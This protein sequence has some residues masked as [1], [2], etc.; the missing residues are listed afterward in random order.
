[1][2][3]LLYLLMIMLVVVA[4]ALPIGATDYQD[5]NPPGSGGGY[6]C[7]T[8]CKACSTDCTENG[9]CSSNCTD[10]TNGSCGCVFSGDQAQYCGGTGWCTYE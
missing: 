4:P 5:Y 1:M 9:N 2:K 10:A 3:R 6:S 8:N 7:V